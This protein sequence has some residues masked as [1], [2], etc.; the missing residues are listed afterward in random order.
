METTEIEIE[1][2]FLL[3]RV[4]HIRFDDVISISQ[5]YLSEKGADKVERIRVSTSDITCDEKLMYTSKERI[6]HMSVNE[7]EREITNKE[8]DELV[9][10]TD[11]S[12]NKVRWV[13]KEGDLKWEVDEM[14]NLNIVI[15]EIEL[16][17][18]DYDLNLPDWI[19]DGIILEITGMHQFSNSN[20][21]E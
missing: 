19:E 5:H 8:W 4:P 6:S 1:R 12:I 14:R 7:T 10:S 9:Q 2:R 17:S 18:E 15:A 11:R 3:K 13:K 21:A 16:P 20:L